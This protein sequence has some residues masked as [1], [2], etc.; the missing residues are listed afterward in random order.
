MKVGGDK[1]GSSFKMNFQIVNVKCPNSV[2]NTCVFSVFQAPDSITNLHIALD[3]YKKQLDELQ[4][5]QWR[6]D[7]KQSY[8]K[9][10]ICMLLTPSET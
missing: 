3:R 7:R 8:N 4:Q 6:L 9:F 2:G 10:V 5:T 1:G